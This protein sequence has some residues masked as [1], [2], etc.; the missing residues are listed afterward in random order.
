MVL[1]SRVTRR[2]NKYKVLHSAQAHLS[3]YQLASTA[4]KQRLK[5]HFSMSRS[6]K[7]AAGMIVIMFGILAGTTLT[8]LV[9]RMFWPTS[10]RY[11]IW[12]PNFTE[13]F[14]PAPGVMPGVGP[15]GW[16]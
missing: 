8:E 2:L 3:L 4:L 6:R 14:T 9:L 5:S 12:L 13:T 7:V 1:G 15:M 11:S 10:D 16:Q